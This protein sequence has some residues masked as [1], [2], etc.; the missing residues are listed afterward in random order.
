MK[1]IER[2]HVV[3]KRFMAR[4]RRPQVQFPKTEEKSLGGSYSW[5]VNDDYLAC[6]ALIIN[7]NN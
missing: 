2:P 3:V 4:D 5:T 6:I 7:I 1:K